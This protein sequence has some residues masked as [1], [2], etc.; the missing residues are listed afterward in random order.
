MAKGKEY[1]VI[2]TESILKSPAYRDLKSPARALL[3]EFLRIY[4]PS[5]NGR[6]TIDTATAKE[7]IKSSE[8]VTDRAFYELSEHGFIK[9]IKH[10]SWTT[11]KGR[12]WAITFHS[13]GQKEPTNEYLRWERGVNMN[14]D[15]FRP[16]WLREALEK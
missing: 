1:F 5:R 3:I 7:L 6:L 14:P 16:K 15:L 11:K 9:L 4:R 10:H 2:L 13:V 8:K 12:E